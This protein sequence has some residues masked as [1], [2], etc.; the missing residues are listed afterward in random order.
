MRQFEIKHGHVLDVLR[1][2]ESESVHCVVTTLF[3]A[4]L[5]I[6]LTRA[7]FLKQHIGL[8]CKL[9]RQTLEMRLACM[10]PRRRVRAPKAINLKAYFYLPSLALHVGERCA[11]KLNGFLLDYPQ[12]VIGSSSPF[13]RDINTLRVGQ[14]R[15]NEIDRYAIRHCQFKSDDVSGRSSARIHLSLNS[16]VTLGVNHS[17]KVSELP[18]SQCG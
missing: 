9:R 14:E 10:H 15:V 17:G 7:E 13:S 2:M 11:Q 3:L 12:P 1:G 16:N 4:R 5:F 8:F 6:Q 18:R